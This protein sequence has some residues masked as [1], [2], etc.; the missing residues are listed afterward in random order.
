MGTRGFID[1]T[2]QGDS[3]V[4]YN[5]FD[6]YPSALGVNMLAWARTLADD[7]S[8]SAAAGAID[9]MRAVEDG[10][11]VPTSEDIERLRPWTNGGVGAPSGAVPSWYQLTRETQGDPAAILAAGVYEDASE[12]PADSL[13]AEWGYTVDLDKGVFEVYEGFQKSPHDLGRYADLVVTREYSHGNYFPVALRASWPLDAL[14]NQDAFMAA[15]TDDYEPE[16]D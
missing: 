10:R 15:L 12:F 13:F 9:S 1:L 16:E 5:H 11:D 2:A 7:A 4:V 8:R 14:P 6:S 3:V